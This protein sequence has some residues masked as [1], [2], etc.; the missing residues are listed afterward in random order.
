[1]SA[2]KVWDQAGIIGKGA[3]GPEGQAWGCRPSAGVG[4][5]VGGAVERP[6]RLGCPFQPTMDP[7][8]SMSDNAIHYLCEN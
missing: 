8:S 4:V 3:G 5:G 2:Q 7:G 6:G 1:M